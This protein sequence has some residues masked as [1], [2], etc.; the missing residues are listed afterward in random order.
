MMTSGAYVE[1]RC[2]ACGTEKVY[3]DRTKA[4][5]RRRAKSDGWSINLNSLECRCPQ[6]RFVRLNLA[7]REKAGAWA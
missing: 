7:R 4:I 6:H 5:G 2:D 3:R 1:V